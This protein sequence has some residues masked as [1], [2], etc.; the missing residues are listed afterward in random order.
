MLARGQA[1][2]IDRHDVRMRRDLGHQVGFG[3]EQPSSID[4]VNALSQHLDR[5]FAAALEH[6]EVHLRDRGGSDGFGKFGKQG[7]DR[8]FQADS[9]DGSLDLLRAAPHDWDARYN[10]ERALALAPEVEQPPVVD[11]E[12]PTPKER[13]AST[14][15]GTLSDLP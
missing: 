13:A 12:P 2:A 3:L 6:R 5:D 9:E 1:V 11:N 4:V 8:L 7:L 10:L 14:L 15:P